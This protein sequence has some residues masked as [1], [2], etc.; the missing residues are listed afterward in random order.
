MQLSKQLDEQIALN[1]QQ[2]GDQHSVNKRESTVEVTALNDRVAELEEEVERVKSST[3]KRIEVCTYVNTCT[4][5]L[6]ALVNFSG[7][8][9]YVCTYVHEF[10]YSGTSLLQPSKIW[11][12]L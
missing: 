11:K 4:Y 5:A 10:V 3:L 6:L 9:I 7:F 2:N 8:N 12:P 1:E